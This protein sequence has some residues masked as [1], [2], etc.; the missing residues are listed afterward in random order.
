MR[1]IK[2]FLALT[3]LTIKVYF[4]YVV[5]ILDWL[6]V[7]ADD[8]FEGYFNYLYSEMAEIKAWAT[9]VGLDKEKV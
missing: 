6:N 8:V 3:D 9:S 1:R 5:L 7:I 2:Y 4:F